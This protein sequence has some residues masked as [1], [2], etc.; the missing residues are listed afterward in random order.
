MKKPA[1]RR[2]IKSQSLQLLGDCLWDTIKAQILQKISIILRPATINLG[3]YTVLFYISHLIPKPSMPLT[4]S[5]E[6]AFM[7]EHASKTKNPIVNLT[8][9]ENERE[10]DRD[11]ENEADAADDGAQSKKSKVTVSI[12]ILFSNSDLIFGLSGKE[13]TAAN[14][15]KT[16][17]IQAL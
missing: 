12:C 1:A 4:T 10:E 5:K 3:H 8:I 11:K 14:L 2:A 13:E 7:I 6:H 9:T 17:H 16:V 15:E